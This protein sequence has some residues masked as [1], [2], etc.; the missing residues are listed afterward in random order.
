MYAQENPSF[1]V[2]CIEPFVS[3]SDKDINLLESQEYTNPFYGDK[4]NWGIMEEANVAEF[5]EWI[6]TNGLEETPLQYG[7]LVLKGLV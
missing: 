7:D 6:K 2:E 1:A 4:T 3:E 5:L